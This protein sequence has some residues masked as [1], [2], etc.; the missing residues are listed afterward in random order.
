MTPEDLAVMAWVY[1]TL[2]VVASVVVVSVAV[3]FAVSATRRADRR[4][5]WFRQVHRK[6]R[7]RIAARRDQ[8][9][10]L[11]KLVDATD[12]HRRGAERLHQNAEQRRREAEAAAAVL[13]VALLAGP[14]PR[15]STSE[16]RMAE[17]VWLLRQGRTANNQ[18]RRGLG[19]W[20]TNSSAVFTRRVAR[21]LFPVWMD[22]LTLDGIAHTAGPGSCRPRAD[23]RRGWV[24]DADDAELL[25]SVRWCPRCTWPPMFSRMN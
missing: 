21:P 1:A 17:F 3:L 15:P 20:P 24:L 25:F 6:Q 12:R 4:R 11:A 13:A 9:D 2:S 14:R 18:G 19:G 7:A 8:V 23:V 10:A 5:E 22:A 16:G